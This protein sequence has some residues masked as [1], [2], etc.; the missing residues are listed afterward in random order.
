ME[1]L[2]ESARLRYLESQHR[3]GLIWAT[4]Y[5]ALLKRYCAHLAQRLWQVPISTRKVAICLHHVL[6]DIFRALLHSQRH[7]QKTI[8]RALHYLC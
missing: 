4:L 8:Q 1:E 2:Y 7:L 5:A 3:R 6:S